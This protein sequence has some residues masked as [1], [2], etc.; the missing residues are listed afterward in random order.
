FPILFKKFAENENC[1]IQFYNYGVVKSDLSH[2]KALPTDSYLKLLENVK[3]KGGK[4]VVGGGEVFFANW[5]TLY[6][7]INPIYLKISS[8]NFFNRIDN[9]INFS[10]YILSKNKVDVP[11]CPSKEELENE[12][13]KIYFSSVGGE[14]TGGKNKNSNQKLSKSLKESA[15]L[16]VRDE[17]T[18]LSMKS[19]DLDAK[20]IPDSAIIMS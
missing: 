11:F 18:F 8:N 20:L 6:S 3:N 13:I 19:M 1:R 9:K 17:R 5:K 2:Y 4:L 7:F 16:S 10:K 14:F 15:L 12:F